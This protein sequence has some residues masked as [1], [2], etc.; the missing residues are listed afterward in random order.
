MK[1]G[2]FDH[3]DRAAVSLT[4]QYAER[5]ELI[6]A[7]DRAGFYA[8]HVAEHHATPLGMAPSPSVFLAC[9]A[10]RTT[11]LRLGPL[12]YQLSL[13]HPI[14]VYEE[15]C[16]LDH[17]SNGRLELGVGRG[18]SP[19]E[20]AYY[21]T[22]PAEAQARYFETYAILMQMFAG[23]TLSYDGKFHRFKDTPIEIEPV[24]RPHPP[25]WYGAVDAA[26]AA[27]AAK[28]AINIVCNVPAPAIR[29]MRERYLA[30]WT[31]AG[32]DLAE[33]ALIAMNRY[34][35][36][37]D[38]DQAAI[39]L[40]RRAYQ[41]WHAS[42]YRLFEL[43]GTRPHN[44]TYPE[45][46]DLA[47][48]QGYAVAGTP[49]TVREALAAQIKT[50]GINYLVCRFAFGD[51]TLIEARHSLNLFARHVMPALAGQRQAAE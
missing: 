1:F 16:M 5:L 17:L 32:R 28:N 27:W 49:D 15:I 8:Y 18:V 47:Q 25:L 2:V 7:Y 12:V 44:A 10:Q 13:Y 30:E 29:P 4:R 9:V 48:D 38:S 36:V 3:L 23:K 19:H 33:L 45:T 51:L 41:C 42:F 39:A 50:A 31:A 26:G 24:Q 22:D 46:F 35:V 11:R 34:I 37:A 20:L 6:E 14:R 40:A 21:G 43:H